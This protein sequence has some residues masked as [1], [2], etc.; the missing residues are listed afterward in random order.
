MCPSSCGVCGI[1]ER[2]VNPQLHKFSI[3]FMTLK[4]LGQNG[5]RGLSAANHVTT[6]PVPSAPRVAGIE[7]EHENALTVDFV[8]VENLPAL[9]LENATKIDAP[10]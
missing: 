2:V 8:W 7:L 6:I 5:A 9:K 3:D 1:G 4:V 10:V